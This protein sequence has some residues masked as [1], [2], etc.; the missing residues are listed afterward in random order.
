MHDGDRLR[1]DCLAVFDTVGSLGI[2][3]EAF[4]RSN[5]E[6][7][8]FHDVELPSITRVN[9]HALAID[10][11]RWP[12][13]ATVWRPSPFR[14]IETITE[15]VWFSGVHADIG[16]GY[17]RSTDMKAA[18]DRADDIT[19]DWL[20][21]RLRTY[22]KDFPLPER[23][24]ESATP[25]DW[26]GSLIHN[27]RLGI[28]RLYPKSWRAISNREVGS[29]G[30]YEVAVG[31]DRHSKSLNEMVHISTIERLWTKKGIKGT[32]Y[33]PKN[34]T[35][36]LPMIEATYRTKTANEQVLLVGWNGEAL[37]PDQS[38]SSALAKAALDAAAKRYNGLA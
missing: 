11:N 25:G 6:H 16:G 30:S 21:R 14:K 23:W 29:L 33:A 4:V 8:E 22:F 27:S 32:L 15:Q 35:C 20:L 18:H 34:L 28:Y 7:Y 5:R 36:I 9:L 24:I 13:Q 10:E 3:L 17:L 19:L 38:G 26:S 37:D 2:P 1:I 31:G 12:F